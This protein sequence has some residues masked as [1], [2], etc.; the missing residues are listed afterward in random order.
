V[1]EAIRSPTATRRELG[2]R[3][4][5]LRLERELTVSGA[6]DGIGCSPSKI[7]KIE[8]AQLVVTRDDVLKL[9]AFYEVSDAGL[10]DLLLFMVRAG[11]R[12]EWWEGHRG[13]WPKFTTY[14]SL[15]SVATT[16]QAYDTHM[17]HGLLQTPDYA[18]ALLRAQLPEL[19]PHEIDRLVE[20]RIKRQEILIRSDPEPLTLWSIMDEAVLRRPVGGKETM[21]AQIQQL[22]ELSTLPNVNLLIMPDDLGAH[23]GMLGP[24]AIMQFEASTRPVVYIEGQAGNLYLEK[25]DDLRRCRQTMI[26][27][28]ATAPGPERSLA[29]MRRA[30]E[31]MKP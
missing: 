9:L 21:H 29:L 8:L 11:A 5:G 12:K 1:S 27:I 24:F 23:P 20:L 4:R 15:E 13:L 31:E 30:A 6:A 22:I 7:T 18:R 16:L 19:L 10:H 17:V 14:L 3:L 25:D 26:H 28:L 2:Q